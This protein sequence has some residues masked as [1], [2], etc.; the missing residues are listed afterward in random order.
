MICSSSACATGQA[1]G[2]ALASDYETVNKE[3]DRLCKTPDQYKTWLA[4]QEKVQSLFKGFL[5]LISDVPDE[6]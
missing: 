3:M 4:D 2:N 6:L 5:D 1:K